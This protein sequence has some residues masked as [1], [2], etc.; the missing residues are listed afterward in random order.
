MVGVLAVAVV[1]VSSAGV[2]VRLAPDAHPL[3]IAFW[4]TALVA[5]LLAPGARLPRRGEALAIAGAGALLAL[6]FWS[7]FASL[8]STSVMRSTVLVCL[9]P[10]WAGLLEAA[11]LRA[12]PPGRWWAGILLS[13]GGVVGLAGLGGGGLTPGDGLATLGG[14]LS[15]AYLVVGRSVRTRVDITTYGSLVCAAAAGCLLLLALGV[16]APLWGF[17]RDAGLAI[18]ALALGPQLLGHIGFN[19][20]VGYV[21]AAVVAAVIL[22]EPVGATALAAAVLGERPTAREVAAGAV[23]LAGVAV[24]VLP[25]RTVTEA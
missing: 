23:I 18:L 24:A 1:A 15:A 21:P 4:R 19:Y 16:R 8:A 12:P 17:D 11:W 14:M 2:L 9:T 5:A 22:L 10:L 20:A 7:W 13:L 25:R 6:H 3:T